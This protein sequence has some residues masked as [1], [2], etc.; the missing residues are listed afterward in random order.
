MIV[1]FPSGVIYDCD[2]PKGEIHDCGIPQWS[3]L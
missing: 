1:A 2:I 3:D